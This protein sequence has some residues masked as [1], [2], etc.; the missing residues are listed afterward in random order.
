M[1]IISLTY[2][3]PLKE[4]DEHLNAHVEYLNEQYR[5]GN[6][7]ASGR[8]IPRTGGIILSA[9]NSREALDKV[10]RLDPFHRHEVA[11]YE[12]IEFAASMTC[13]ELEFLKDK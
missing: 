10:I 4:V 3:R 8:K 9:M 5:L 11:Q 7:L 1:F 2:Q 6:F 12:V 13:K